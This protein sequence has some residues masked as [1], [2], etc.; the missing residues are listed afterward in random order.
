MDKKQFDAIMK[1]A[2]FRFAIRE[3]RRKHE[4]QVSLGLWVGMGAAMVSLKGWVPV[5]VLTLV[6]PAIIIGHALFWVRWNWMRGER[7][8]RLVYYYIKKAEWMVFRDVPKPR[9]QHFARYEYLYG[10]LLNGPSLFQVLATTVLAIGLAL[11]THQIP[12]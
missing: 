2:D 11:F 6:L 7:D 9:R 8:S 5:P 10:F 4:W 1:L 12:S 3:A